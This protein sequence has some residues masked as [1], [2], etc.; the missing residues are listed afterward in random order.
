MTNS[1]FSNFRLFVMAILF[2]SVAGGATLA[3]T[4][5]F[6]EGLDNTAAL[7][8]AVTTHTTLEGVNI[9][10]ICTLN[11]NNFR[12]VLTNTTSKRVNLRYKVAGESRYRNTNLKAGQARQL[13]FRVRSGNALEVSINGQ[14]AQVQGSAQVCRTD[15]IELTSVCNDNPTRRR[16]RLRNPNN[17]DVV[18]SWKLYGSSKSGTW[19]LKRAGRGKEKWEGAGAKEYHFFE[20]PNVGGP[21]TL[22]VSYGSNQRKTKA[23]CNCV[24][25]VPNGSLTVTSLCSDNYLR[26][27]WEVKNFNNKAVWVKLDHNNRLYK[28]NANKSRVFTTSDK[29]QTFSLTYGNNQKTA[30]VSN[31]GGV[32]VDIPVGVQVSGRDI[33]Y[34]DNNTDIIYKV[35]V[36]EQAGTATLTKLFKSPYGGTHMSLNT[37][38]DK[39]Y[40]VQA[41]GENRYGYLDL[42]TYEYVQVGKLNQNGIYQVT[43][44]PYGEMYFAAN[45][46][47]EVMV[48]ADPLSGQFV[49]YGGIRLNGSDDIIDLA[50]ADMAF[51]NDGS[52]YVST[53]SG[54]AIHTVSGTANNLRAVQVASSQNRRITGLAVLNGGSGKLIYSARDQRT[55]TLVDALTGDTRDLTLQ[56]DL[57]K[58][59][60]WGD[61]TSARL[62]YRDRCGGYASAVIEYNVGTLTNGTRQPV[63]ERQNAANALGAP[64]E[65][66]VINFVSLGLNGN[67]VLELSSPVYNH[68]KNGIKVKNPK[69]INYGALDMADMVIVETSYGRSQSNCG[70]DQNRNYP[71]RIMV[72]G[73]QSLTDSS[74]VLLTA[75]PECRSSFID[76]APAVAAGLAYVKY[77]KIVDVTNPR[78]FPGNADGFDVDGV[79]ICPD[80]VAAA[81]TGEG[82]ANGNGAIANARVSSNPAYDGDFF[83]REPNEA[84]SLN[85]MLTLFPNPASNGTLRIATEGIW[86]SA[87]VIMTDLMGRAV[88]STLVERNNPVVNVSDLANGT[89]I[90]TVN[91]EGTVSKAKVYV[92]NL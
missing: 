79:I 5:A 24:C 40:L 12:W 67:I 86:S 43:F 92:S 16:W 59:L 6:D 39:L 2:C 46:K 80:D 87:E 72:Y 74:W 23:S 21:N 63:A 4:Y 68:N 58:P 81:I 36:D 82:R 38:G 78:Y 51:D 31:T 62:D 77:I 57:E 91:I 69:S 52:F 55:M 15:G 50:G 13:T 88:L 20:T 3:K 42:N 28:I 53:H 84:G 70:P 11:P 27:K 8:S 7:T 85:S 32:C 35:G 9:E 41:N 66:D 34:V 33:L 26:A 49:S 10:S 1:T 47:E 14:T 75:T 73:K 18:V 56:G 90:V 76:V 29:V 45:K 64:Q 65:T 89:Y 17:W 25:P 44:S 30:P 22:V 37:Q 60:G 48:M 83:N 19:T 61:M 54:R 71:E